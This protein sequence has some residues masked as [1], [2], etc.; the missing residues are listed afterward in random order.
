MLGALS[1]ALVQHGVRKLQPQGLVAAATQLQQ[2]RF[3][4]IHEYQ[5]T[6]IMRHDLAASGTLQHEALA[7]ALATLMLM[8]G[9]EIMKKFGINVPEGKPAKSVEEVARIAKELADD[10]GE[11]RTHAMHQQQLRWKHCGLSHVV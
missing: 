9:A 10:K 8:Q 11:V 2:C 5:V 4:N 7:E 6:V 3:L 1:R